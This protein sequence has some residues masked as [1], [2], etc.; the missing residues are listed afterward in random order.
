MPYSCQLNIASIYKVSKSPLSMLISNQKCFWLGALVFKNWQWTCNNV[1]MFWKQDLILYQF[2]GSM[3]KMC[4]MMCNILVKIED[5]GI[6]LKSLTRVIRLYCIISRSQRVNSGKKVMMEEQEVKE[7]F[8][9]LNPLI[10]TNS[11][12]FS[13]LLL[14]LW[15][16]WSH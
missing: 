9:V 7:N 16:Q 14:K 5:I 8:L 12:P 13:S 4:H 10:T 11:H 3:C 1:S 15:Q 6:N 2:T